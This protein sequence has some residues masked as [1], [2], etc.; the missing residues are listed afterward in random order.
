M[1]KT[2]KATLLVSTALLLW[3]ESVQP[4]VAMDSKKAVDLAQVTLQSLPPLA[5]SDHTSFFE[6]LDSLKNGMNDAII[7]GSKSAYINEPRA[8]HAAKLRAALH[9]LTTT[10][11]ATKE[12]SKELQ[13]SRG[14]L[15][16]HEEKLT[17]ITHEKAKVEQKAELERK[18]F[19]QATGM[20]ESQIQDFILNL[21]KS[22]SGFSDALFLMKFS[23]DQNKDFSSTLGK[24]IVQAEASKKVKDAY[25]ADKKIKKLEVYL[26]LPSQK[27][28]TDPLVGLFQKNKIFFFRGLVTSSSSS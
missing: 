21:Q 23:G 17:Q 10:H 8:A 5:L 15:K 27:V 7:E 18:A 20:T 11:V 16:E 6:Y 14:Q 24:I 22:L 9:Y 19:S 4:T 2:S 26:Q 1:K 25:E 3:A 28:N 13:I 12:H